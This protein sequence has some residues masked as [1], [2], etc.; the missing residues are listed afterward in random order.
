MCASCE[1]RPDG[2]RASEIHY[3]K[4]LLSQ[5][6]HFRQRKS[7]FFFVLL[8]WAGNARRRAAATPGTTNI[9]QMELFS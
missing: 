5:A 3:A 1:K 4:V 6:R 8:T 2:G 7:S 9:E